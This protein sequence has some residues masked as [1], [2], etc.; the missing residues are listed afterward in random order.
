MEYIQTVDVTKESLG[1]KLGDVPYRATALPGTLDHFVLTIVGVVG[2]VADVGYVHDVFHRISG[3]FEGAPEK[4]YENVCPKVS[5]VCV[6][7]DGRT[8]RVQSDLR[9]VDRFEL[10]SCSAERIKKGEIHRYPGDCRNGT[11]AYTTMQVM[12][13][14]QDIS[15]GINIRGSVRFDEPMSRHTTF[16][17]GGPADVYTRPADSED[18]AEL[19]RFL[20]EH[21]LPWFIIG[22]GANIVVADAGIRAV[23][24]DTGD[25]SEVTIHGTHIA[26]G[27]GLP[28]SDA[29][30][31]AARA[32]LGGL[33]FLYS[34]PG[35]TGGAVWM[36]ARCYGS[37]VIDILE[38]VDYLD[39]TGT[40]RTMY[41]ERE[42]FAYKRTPFQEHDWVIL[43]A[44]F[45]LE[46]EPEEEIR[47]RMRHYQADRTS[48]GHFAWPCAGSLF[49]NNREFGEPTGKLL[50]RLDMRGTRRGGA[51]ISPLHANI[52]VNDRGASAH[53]IEELASLMEQRA[54]DELGYCLEREVRFIGDWARQ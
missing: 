54:R 18:L 34:M 11:V 51:R 15:R 12:H 42:A 20:R 31:A 10:L 8:T 16:E 25:M 5:Y 30:E 27:A 36:N 39:E 19:I 3:E 14:L 47:S 37:S 6:V 28:V 13:T 38:R 9:G 40:R 44:V 26:V 32:S 2:E 23:V 33:D 24:V 43:E 48:K 50:D 52:V 45:S 46:P 29:A 17:V 22:G 35:S 41:P 4:I 7:I 21:E 53:D 49:K 1:I